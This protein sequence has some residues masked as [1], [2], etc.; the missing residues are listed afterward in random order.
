MRAPSLAL[1]LVLMTAPAIAQDDAN[2]LH[3]GS[4]VH[5]D[6]A[7][8]RI[9]ISYVQPRPGLA[10]A[11]VYPGAVL[12]D[13]QMHGD[14]IMGEARAWK[15]GCTPAGYNVAGRIEA[16]GFV[17]IGPG[18]HRRGCNVV[19]LTP[20]SPHSRLPFTVTAPAVAAVLAAQADPRRTRTA[21]EMLSVLR[22]GANREPSPAPSPVPTPIA[23]PVPAPVAPV[24]ASVPSEAP[25]TPQ[26]A[27]PATPVGPVPQA[28]M[29]AP[30]IPAPE[31]PK[32]AVATPAPTQTPAQDAV[33]PAPL[34]IP[35]NPP[36]A[37]APP[38]AK[39]KLDADL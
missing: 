18:P 5:I 3:N 28:V 29:V 36:P 1:A 34:P 22:P 33:Q 4:A 30:A 39:P 37:A 13:G 23:A 32:V 14:V 25:V 8:E 24:A 9:R 17:L 26:S 31:R 11:G 6:I 35:L 16:G 27:A 21:S 38:K 10:E 7:G 20:N 2:A 19:S 12:F 15:A